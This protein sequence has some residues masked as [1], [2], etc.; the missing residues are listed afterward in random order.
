[1]APVLRARL[2]RDA[3]N[4]DVFASSRRCHQR[5][6]DRRS[7]SILQF[8]KNHDAAFAPYVIATRGHAPAWDEVLGDGSSDRSC[9]RERCTVGLGAPLP[10]KVGS[11][12]TVMERVKADPKAGIDPTSSKRARRLRFRSREAYARRSS[13]VPSGRRERCASSCRG[14][15]RA[16]DAGRKSATEAP[17]ERRGTHRKS[18][19]GP[20]EIERVGRRNR[21]PHWTRAKTST[22]AAECSCTSL[23]TSQNHGRDQAPAERSE[24]G[25]HARCAVARAALDACRVPATRRTDRRRYQG[26]DAA[27]DRSAETHGRNDPSAAVVSH[28]GNSAASW[29]FPCCAPTVRS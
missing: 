13:R 5:I 12:V 2:M 16:P 17:A 24:R 10:R 29:R 18:S 25:D 26:P 6:A 1:M 19:C 20:G 22:S 8:T 23:A 28:F 15:C 14:A 9:R 3:S 27:A 4:A 7:R 21:W 11:S